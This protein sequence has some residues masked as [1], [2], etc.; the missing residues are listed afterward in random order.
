MSGEVIAEHRVRLFDKRVRPVH[1]E[2]DEINESYRKKKETYRT[3]TIKKF[4]ET[5]PKE[6]SLYVEGLKSAVTANLYWHIDEIMKYTLIYSVEDVA[7]VLSECIEIGAYHKNSVKRLLQSREPQKQ[8]F[9]CLNQPSI[10][11][12]IDIRRPLA[13][14]KLE[15]AL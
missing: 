7:A 10:V 13:G 5:F 11:C 9:D 15:A 3:E 1:P 6:G 12:S 14:Y 2:H 8:T 4:I